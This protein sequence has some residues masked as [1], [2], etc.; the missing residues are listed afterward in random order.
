MVNKSFETLKSNIIK[1]QDY[2]SAYEGII[3]LDRQLKYIHS[4]GYYVTSLNTRD[5]VYNDYYGFNEMDRN[6]SNKEENIRKNI[7]DFVKLSLGIYVSLDVGGNIVYD[8]T[9]YD[10]DFIIENYKEGIR[11][12]IKEECVEYYDRIISSK[13]FGGVEDTDFLYLY[14]YNNNN[15]KDRFSSKQSAS[16]VKATQTGKRMTEISNDAFMKT[17]FFPILFGC[18]F[19]TIGIF[20]LFITIK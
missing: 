6:Y 17:A 4:R 16:L 15:K 14:D 10:D 5:I 1:N 3:S 20:M 12:S 8:Y 13:L 18:L 19:L 7:K 11:P 9:K 2:D